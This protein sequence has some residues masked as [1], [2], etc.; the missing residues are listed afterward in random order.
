LTKDLGVMLPEVRSL[1]KR[2][3]SKQSR[4]ILDKAE[5]MDLRIKKMLAYARVGEKKDENFAAIDFAVV[6]REARAELQKQIE[7]TGAKVTA[8]R[9]PVLI[10]HRDSMKLVLRNLMENAIKYRAKRP[11]KV[12]VYAELQKN[13]WLFIVKDNGMGIRKHYTY[14]PHI[15]NWEKI[16]ELFKRDEVKGP[17]GEEIPG[18]GIGLSYCQRVIERHGGKIWVESEVGKGSTFYFTSPAVPE[19]E[20]QGH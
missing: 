18:H 19:A 6:F 15:N 4:F 13:E 16:F 10:A 14:T 12:R 9:L 20:D 7:L 2:L 1:A 5:D 17:E 3:R 8:A 11:L